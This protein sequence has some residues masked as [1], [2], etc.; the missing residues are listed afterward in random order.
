MVAATSGDVTH[1]Q[2]AQHFDSSF[3][4]TPREFNSGGTRHLGRISKTGDRYLRML[5]TH[6][7]RS[8]L[9]APSAAVET[10]KVLSGVR[11]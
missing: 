4:L 11:E 5:L 8:V 10:G 6:G 1:F 3:G 9:R 2:D 7:E